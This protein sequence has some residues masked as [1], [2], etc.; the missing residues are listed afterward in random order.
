MYVCIYCKYIY[1]YY[2]VYSAD[3]FVPSSHPPI[4]PSSPSPSSKGNKFC[5]TT[6]LRSSNWTKGVERC[7]TCRGPIS[8]CMAWNYEKK[9][10]VMLAVMLF[11]HVGCLENP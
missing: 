2:I 7:K 5:G 4:M 1:I 6:S 3:V 11:V 9:T 8:V 10:L